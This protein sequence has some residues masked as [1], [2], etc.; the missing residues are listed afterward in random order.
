M[1]LW[2]GYNLTFDPQYDK[3][4]VLITHTHKISKKRSVLHT[5]YHLKENFKDPTAELKGRTVITTY[6]VKSH[7]IEEV[8]EDMTPL[9]SFDRRYYDGVYQ[10]TY[11]QYLE[12]SY[13]TTIEHNDQPMLMVMDKKTNQPIYLVPELCCLTDFEKEEIDKSRKEVQDKLYL[14]P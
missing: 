12:E 8:R 1:T 2:Q 10:S 4:D 3:V 7:K 6:N 13:G 9:S 14:D 11:K 5:I